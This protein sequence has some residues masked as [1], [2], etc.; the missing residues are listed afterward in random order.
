MILVSVGVYELEV[1][2]P[3]WKGECVATV[4]SELPV[5][6]TSSNSYLFGRVK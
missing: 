2:R 5:F 4:S 1:T 6:S 3:K